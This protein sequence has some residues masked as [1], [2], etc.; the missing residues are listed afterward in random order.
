M[1]M[2][3]YPDET[4]AFAQLPHLYEEFLLHQAKT[5]ANKMT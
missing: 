1:M 5:L 3:S 2:K 4:E